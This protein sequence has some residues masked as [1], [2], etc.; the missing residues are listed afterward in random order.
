MAQFLINN[1]Y[2]IFYKIFLKL[3]IFS[4]FGLCKPSPKTSYRK[5]CFPKTVTL[6][7]ILFILT[8]NILH[9]IVNL[10]IK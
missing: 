5:N 9:S 7:I 2:F 3:S 1:M 10:K 8:I 4:Y 6:F